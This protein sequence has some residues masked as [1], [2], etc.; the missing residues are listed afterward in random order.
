MI[1]AV[2]IDD[3]PLA[4]ENLRLLLSS[5]DEISIIGEASNAIEGV[6]VVN[7]QKPDIV[8]LDI[9]M[10]KVSGLEMIGMLDPND[11]PYIIL[12]TA[13]DEYAIKAFEE[14][15]FDYLLKPVESE[16]LSKTINR[17][18]SEL[19]EDND[20]TKTADTF[21]MKI[22]CTGHSKIYL[23]DI[24]DIVYVGSDVTGVYVVKTDGSKYTSELTLSNLEERTS[25][26]R[27]HRQYL[28]NLD[29]LREIDFSIANQT[30][31]Q[32]DHNLSVPISRR[33][34]KPL[35]ETLGLVR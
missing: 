18:Y 12:V 1:T 28:L 31:A 13:Y 4:R 9:Q 6:R 2:I 14:H 30:M 10:P 32:M 15:V 24:E 3:E 21:L 17:L 11:L 26:V 29:H 27:C 33:Y 16:R 23:V 25:L 34:F 19:N 20:N 5:Y 35:K 8:F 22:P 7:Q